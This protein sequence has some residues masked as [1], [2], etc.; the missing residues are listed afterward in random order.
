MRLVLASQ[1]PRRA[2]LLRAAGFAFDVSAPAE[3]DET[4]HEGENPLAYVARVAEAKVSLTVY[5]HPGCCVVGADTAVVVARQV[6]GKP[7]D[8][9]AAVRMLQMLSGREHQVLTGVAVHMGQQRAG[10]VVVTRVRFAPMTDA[11]IGWYVATGEPRDKAGAY[12]I[13]GLA[14]RFVVGIEGSYTNVVGLPVATLYR[15]LERVEA[16]V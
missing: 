10:E 13:Q 11:E 9:D 14:S 4:R 16:D 1:S 5:R 2:A 12:G 3:T 7:R 8:D 15:L 6:L